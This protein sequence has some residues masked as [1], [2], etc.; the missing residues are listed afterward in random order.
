MSARKKQQRYQ[1]AFT[2]GLLVDGRTVAI[3]SSHAR[4]VLAEYRKHTKV[5]AAIYEIK[6]IKFAHLRDDKYTVQFTLADNT[7]PDHAQICAEML[8][9]YDDDCNYPVKLFADK[10]AGLIFAKLDSFSR[11]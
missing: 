11:I 3:R 8:I 10:P 9:D 7:D 2:V 4:K 6:R 5:I 1:A